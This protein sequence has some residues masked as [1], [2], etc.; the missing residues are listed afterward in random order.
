MQKPKYL[1]FKSLSGLAFRVLKNRYGATMI[2]ALGWVTFISDIDLSFIIQ[3]QVHLNKMKG[4]VL[5]IS[6]KND[7]LILKLLELEENPQVLERIAR[8]RYFMKKPHE[9]VYRIENR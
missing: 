9:E 8:E 4:E 7:E 5:K 1:I 3:E 6:K 2:L